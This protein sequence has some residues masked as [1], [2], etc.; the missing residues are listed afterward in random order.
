MSDV[1]QRPTAGI[2]SNSLPELASRIVR[3]HEAI[4]NAPQLFLAQ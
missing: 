3:E 1:Q 4:R 2:G